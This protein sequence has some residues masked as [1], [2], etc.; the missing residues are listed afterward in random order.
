MQQLDALVE[1]GC[2]LASIIWTGVTLAVIAW[3]VLLLKGTGAIPPEFYQAEP[4]TS[5]QLAVT[6]VV[7]VWIALGILLFLLRNSALRASHGF[8]VLCAAATLILYA[9]VFRE[10]SN[11][12]DYGDYIQAAQNL[13]A[14]MPFHGRYLYPPLFAHLLSLLL[15]DYAGDIFYLLWTVNLLSVGLFA[16]LLCA[17]LQRYGFSQRAAAVCVFAFAAINVPML[18]TLAYVQVNFFVVNAIFLALLWY[19]RHRILSALALALAAHFKISPC[20][21]AL[22]LLLCWDWRWLAAFGFGLALL[23]APTL[24]EHGIDPF[25][26]SL[27]NLQNIYS[28]NGGVFREN[29]VDSLLRSAVILGFSSLQTATLLIQI[30]RGALMALGVVA[31]VRAIRSRAFFDTTGSSALVFNAVP[32]LMLTM[33]VVSPLMWEHHPVFA[34]LPF[35]VMLRRM[36]SPGEWVAYGFALFLTYYVPTFDF[37]PWSYGR[38]VGAVTLLVLMVKTSSAGQKG[39]FEVIRGAAA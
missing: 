33:M 22:P 12:G 17:L 7:I 2:R 3:I 15:P 18:R 8:Q 9:N 19:P 27:A 5:V 25:L 32:P 38:L 35:L 16:F 13:S 14:H 4:G 39:T 37:Y 10:H 21:L 24:R 34:A 29:S 6:T 20:L 23:A 11:Y 1:R 26:S 36:S 28:A 31:L 30:S